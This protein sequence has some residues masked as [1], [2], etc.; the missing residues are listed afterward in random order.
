MKLSKSLILIPFILIGCGPKEETDSVEPSSTIESPEATTVGVKAANTAEE[1]RAAF[2]EAITNQ[3]REALLSLYYTAN[4][5]QTSIDLLNTSLD[6]DLTIKD[7]SKSYTISHI[8]TLNYSN[9]GSGTNGEKV[10]YYP[11]KYL[12]GGLYLSYTYKERSGRGLS[13]FPIMNIDGAYYLAAQKIEDLP[14]KAEQTFYRISL[15]D[16]HF[17]T[18]APLFVTYSA[19]NYIQMRE[20]PG[21]DGQLRFTKLLSVSCP[22]IPTATEATLLVVN[23]QDKNDILLELDFDPQFGLYWKNEED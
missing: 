3:D 2:E 6:Y 18:F 14:Q 9:Y 4:L 12:S 7:I 11:T 19:G 15:K 13:S 23:T 16:D 21:R 22:P 5:D 20:L 8:E 10:A 1:L 17:Q